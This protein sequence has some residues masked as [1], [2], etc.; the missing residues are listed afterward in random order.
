M[1]SE[2]DGAEL[3]CT[4]AVERLNASGQALK[5]QLLR[6]AHV[7]LGRNEFQ[8]IVLRVHDG[9]VQQTFKL[10]EIQLFTRFARDGKSTIRVV[11]ENTQVLISDCPPDRLRVF[12]KTLSIKHQAWQG[13]TPIG[14]RAKL[15]SGLPRSF[16]TISPL[17]Q[18]DIQQANELRGKVNAPPP[19]RGPAERHGNRS[20]GRQVKRDS[21]DYTECS[22]VSVPPA[23]CECSG[24][25]AIPLMFRRLKLCMHTC[26]RLF[27]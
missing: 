15:L 3:Q 1:L 22:P 12:L 10:R 9:K 21:P 20:T 25:N 23:R 7:T 16:E 13:K 18:K 27:I 5:R 17:Q 8:E 26:M 14:D 6:R 4:V 24:I 11:P 2:E 19:P